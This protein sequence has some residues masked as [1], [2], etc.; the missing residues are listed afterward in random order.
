MCVALAQFRVH[1]LVYLVHIDD[2]RMNAQLRCITRN[3]RNAVIR[4]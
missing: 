2:N 3:R 1:S 4:V